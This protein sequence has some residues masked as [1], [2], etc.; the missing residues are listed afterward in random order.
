MS[1]SC[2]SLRRNAAFKSAA[3]NWE[4]YEVNPGVMPYPGGG[5]VGPIVVKER[6]LPL[7][8]AAEALAAEDRERA[9]IEGF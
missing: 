5:W 9:A 7:V 6:P 3:E 4:K 2:E 1:M 8:D